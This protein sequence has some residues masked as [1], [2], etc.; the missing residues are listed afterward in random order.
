[1]NAVI[2]FSVVVV[3]LLVL[4]T[5][6]FAQLTGTKTV[7]TGGDYT[8]L[9][10]AINDLNTQGVGSG[11]VT[12]N[13]AA[14]ETFNENPP[15]ITATGTS[16]DPIVF[17]KNGAGANPLVIPST[18]GTITSTTFGANADAIIKIVGGDYI[19][20]NGIDVQD[21]A[22]FTTAT[23]KFEYGYML[24]K[25]SGTDA[26]KNVTIRNATITLDKT[27]VI[28]SGVY[29]SNVDGAGAAVTVTS[30]G[31]RSE[32]VKIHNNTI[33]NI[34]TGIQLRG[35]NHTTAPRDYYDHFVDVGVDGAN[36][37]TNYGGGSATAYGVYAIYQ[38]SLKLANNTINGGTG[39]TTTLYGIFTSTG[40]NSAVDIYGN[41]VTIAGGGTTSTIYA[42]NN[43]MGASGTDNTVNIYNNIVENCSYP[44]ATSGTLYCLYQSTSPMTVNI[45][46]NTVRNNSKPGTGIMYC[47]YSFNTATNGA[48]NVYNNTVHGNSNTGTGSM[49]CVYSNEATTTAK[50]TYG[51]TVYGNS[52]A[53]GTLYGLNSST[54]GTTHVFKNN[55][56]DLSNSG[57]TG[58]VYGI[59]IGSGVTVY[60]YNNFVSDL[61]TP[62]SDGDDRIRGIYEVS[63]TSSN[64]YYF[65]YNTVYLD[66]TSTGTNFST[67]AI[68]ANTGPTVEMR[69]NILINK[70]TPT[71]TGRA[72]VYRRSSTTIG[73]YST[74]SN[75]NN[76]YAGTPSASNLIFYDGTNSD[77]TIGDFKTRVSPADGNSFTE[78]SPFV[79]VGTTPYNLH[80]QTTVATQTE[81][82]GQAI[83]TP[84]ITQDFDGDTRNATT[85]DVGAD[86]FNGIGADLTSPAISYDVLP[87]TYLTGNR[88]IKARITD[89]SG[90]QRSAAGSPR[91]YYKK[92]SGG[93]YFSDTGV[94]APADSFSF[95][96]NTATLGG[97]T[98]GDTV[99]YYVAAQDSLNNAGTNPGGTSPTINPPNATVANPNFY[100]VQPTIS[101]T[102]TIGAGPGPELATFATIKAFF[103]SVNASFVDGDIIANITSD[104]AETATATLNEVAYASGGP[105]RILV[106][107]SGGSWVASGDIAGALIDL[108]GA[109]YVTFDGVGKT[110][111]YRN[112]NTASTARTFL[113]RTDATVDTIRNSIIEGAS[114]STVS[115]VIVVSTSV[116]GSTGNSNLVFSGNDIRDRSDVTGVPANLIYA[117][118]T[119]AAPNSNITIT[120]NNLFNWTNI[121]V[122]QSSTGN[123][124]GWSI[125]SN[126]FY[127]TA[128]R[129]ATLKGIDLNT[130]SGHTVS[131]N[132]FGGSAPNRS[133]APLTNT[134]G[135]VIAFEFTVGTTAPT[136]IQ[137]NTFSNIDNSGVTLSHLVNVTGGNVNIGTTTGN[138]IGGG[139]AAY[140]TIRTNYDIYCIYNTGSGIVNISNNTIRYVTNTSIG[141]DWLNGIRSTSGT[142][143]ITNNTIRN[144]TTTATSTTIGSLL[145]GIYISASTAAHLVEGNTIKD[146]ASLATGTSAYPVS[147]MY[148]SVT[149][150]GTV[151]SRNNISGLTVAGTGTGTGS[152]QVFGIYISS[153]RGTYVNNMI[154]V[155]I[156]AGDESRIV[157]IR[158][159]ASS[160]YSNNFYYNTVH[161]AGAT[162]TGVNNSYAFWRS[163]ADTVSIMNNIFNNTRTTGGT[164]A[165]LAI[166]NT[167]TNANG[168]DVNASNYNVLNAV[169]SSAVGQ[170]LSTGSPTSMSGWQTES[171]GDNNS[172]SGVTVTFVDAANG[173][174]HMNMGTTPTSLESAGTVILSYTT[175]YDNQTRPGPPG[176]VNGGATAPDLGADEFDGVPAPL[177]M[178]VSST[179]AQGATTPV[180][181]GT[182]DNGII[183]IQVVTS[184][185][186]NPLNATSITFNTAGSTNPADIANAKVF[187]TGTSDVFST[188]NQFGST[189]ATPS[190]QMV[191]TGTQAL[192]TGTNYFW[193]SYDIAS[194]A[195]ISNVV[196]GQA[197]AVVVGGVNRIPSVTN[198]AGSRTI[199]GPFSGNYTIGTAQPAPYNSITSALAA[200]MLASAN[201]PVTFLLEDASYTET[202]PVVI[203]S[204]P[205]SSVTNTLTIKPAPATTV[206]I[207]G[208]SG[209]TSTS[210]FKFNRCDYVIIDGSNSGG[211]SRD[212]TIENTSTNTS[213]AAIWLSSGG[214][215]SGATNNVIK[216]CILKCGAD[217]STGTNLTFGIISSGA[218]I[219][220]ATDGDDND[221]NTFQNNEI[222]KVR[223]GIYLRG[224]VANQNDGNTI[225]GNLVGPT[226]FGSDQIGKDGIVVEHQ[227]A[228]TITQ[229]TIRY[230]GGTF[231]TTTSGTDR[232]A[233]GLGDDA[234]TSPLA[235]AISNATVTRNLIY[236]IIEERTF[237]AVGILVASTS[238]P[239]NNLIANNVM[240]N[241]RANGTVSDHAV[242]I[243]MDDLVGDVV[244]FNSIS[245]IGD[246]DPAPAT[247]ATQS[248]TGIRI[249]IAADVTNLTL[250]DNAIHIDLTSN[251]DTLRHYAIV[252]P[253]A[254]YSWGT[255]GAD[256]ND[257]YVNTANAQMAL[258]GL[259]TSVPYTPVTTLVAWQGTFTPPQ[260]AFSIAADPMYNAPNDLR[261]L[262]GSPLLLA[263]VTI[264]GI[265]DDFLGTPRGG[266]PTI[267]GYEVAGDFSG[268]FIGYTLLGNTSSTSNRSLPGVA[269]TDVSGVNVTAGT[270]PRVYYKRA[271]DANAFGGANN[272]TFNGWKW[273]ETPGTTSPFSFT[274]D[275]S[276]L[277]G[278]G[279]VTAGD[280]V[281][282]FVV[283]QDLAGPF[284]S[285]NP[286]EGF[287]ATSVGSI[288]SGPNV[289]NS[290]KIIGVPMAGDFTIGLLDFNK[291]SGK[292]LTIGYTTKIVK[293]EVP[294]EER[295]EGSKEEHLTRAVAAEIL[296]PAP[297]A[298]LLQDRP[299]TDVPEHAALVENEEVEIPVRIRLVDVEVVVPVLM[300]GDVPYAGERSAPLPISGAEGGPDAV[301]PTITAAMTD[302]AERGVGGAVRFL[303]VDATYPSETYPISVGEI[304]GSSSVNTVTLKPQTGI[305]PV[306]SGDAAEMFVLEGA[307]NFIFDGSNTLAGTTRDMTIRNINTG[308]IA[309][310][311]RNDATSNTIKNC[312]LE[313]G[314]TGSTEATIMFSTG[315]AD[316]NSGNTI[317]NNAIRDRSDVTS[318]APDNGIYSSG[319]TTARNS[320]NTITNNEIFNFGE[321]GVE[322]SSTGNG[323]GWVIS[324][325]HFYDNTGTSN[326]TSRVV[327][328]ALGGINSSGNTIEDNFIGG[329]A[330]NAGGTPWLVGGIFTGI[331][332]TCDSV[333]QSAIDN[334]TVQNLSLTGTGSFTGIAVTTGRA[335]ISN[336]TVGHN[337]TANSILV[338]GTSTT[339]G[340]T[341]SSTSITNPSTVTGNLVANLN[342]TGTGTSVRVR[343][344]NF[345][346]ASQF[347][348]M[349]N[350]IHSLATNST[351]TGIGATSPVAVG[352]HM[353]T[354]STFYPGVL[355]GNTVY[356]IAA[357]NTG[358][359]GSVATGMMLTNFQGPATKNLIYDV[360]NL[361]TGT[362]LT[363]PPIA[364]GVYMR[365]MDAAEFSN[366]MISVGSDQ[367]TNTQFN[368]VWNT[369][370][371][372]G[373][374][375][376]VAYNSISVAG[377][378]SSG[379]IPGFA[380]MRGDNTGF[381]PNTALTLRN[382]VF[383]N[384]RSGGTGKH[385]AIANQSTVP[386]DTGW[387]STASNYNVLH[388]SN[389]ATLGLWAS[390]DQTFAG[391]QTASG[392]DSNSVTG[393]PLFVGAIDLHITDENSP[394]SNAGTPIVGITTD[395][396]GETRNA[397][398]PDIGGDE[399]GGGGTVTIGVPVAQNWN[400][401]SLPVSDPVP[402]DSVKH[403]YVNSAN[404]YAFAFVGGYVQRFVMEPGPGYWVK[405][406][407]AYTQ[408]ITGTARDTLSIPVANNWNMIGSISTSIDT[409]VAHVTPTPANLRASNYFRYAAGYVVATTIDPGS[410]YWVK[411]NGAG[412]FFMHVTGPSAKAS[413]EPTAAGKSIEDLN[414]LT[415]QDANGGSQ[416]LYFGADGNNEIPVAMF[417]MPPAPPAGSFDARFESAEGGL[418][419]QTHGDEVNTVVD[420]PITVQSSAPTGS[421][422]T[423]S[424]KVNGTTASYELSDGVVSHAVRGEGTLKITNSEASHLVLKV[425]GSGVLPEEFALMQ[426]YPNPFNPTTNIRFAL[427]VESR[428]TV[429]IYNVLGQRVKTL[430][431]EQRAAGFHTVEWNGTG[432]SGQQLGSGAYFLRLE[433]QG[434]DGSSFNQFRKMVLVK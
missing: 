153:G 263:G 355:S 106:R 379:A 254:A 96:I 69:N 107:P 56:Y 150:L 227:D 280:T 51:N 165:D 6:A 66:A 121:A 57:A 432:V 345:T 388:A 387:S 137:G 110:M 112:A 185:F 64:S 290:Y 63:S 50:M 409:S 252:A 410:G 240:Y 363:L 118:G 269:I 39:T 362:T 70:S 123:G 186:S 339:H 193:L 309:I 167:N 325:N 28:S 116:G 12:F 197:E 308:G 5:G 14:D 426:N 188:G 31:G 234:W 422:L 19:T 427:P 323:G 391:W 143:T 356:D 296:A 220:S 283:A 333:S 80:M 291:A 320:S 203:D 272:N 399:F 221:N 91:M 392:G 367:T 200:L 285:A 305:S 44:T 348:I 24:A 278:G 207:S 365:F 146:L 366:N 382:N 287:S 196:D 393:D 396:D 317:T 303:L 65:Y 244:V 386:N 219:G 385:Y 282:Y 404:P 250:K 49:Y 124:D 154:S 179:S 140:D 119:T 293:Q 183:N 298:K 92:N 29:V 115:G 142:N 346:G 383:S 98:A 187:Y 380:F 127:Q 398:T 304:V 184:G 21:N 313:G 215:G 163:S 105:Y 25:A 284:V 120:G 176:S 42:I 237:S 133:G 226:A 156:G 334:N 266:T 67:A 434:T 286:Y 301:Y 315:I 138:I 361:S 145:N 417:A 155:G 41:T 429:E 424:W 316:G 129:A 13:V 169:V 61:R 329:T 75:S 62:A 35:Y 340:I 289:P 74:A 241:I 48:A 78:N 433:A 264:P 270:K 249:T 132:S 54:G 359:L 59:Y 94:E 401:V 97:V 85:P 130:G 337:T 259:G 88:S 271:T 30:T 373:N 103:D 319:T 251:T 343:G 79:N 236:N 128:N 321:S 419:V 228:V 125:S 414:T 225:S 170:W 201:G 403:I 248:G 23:E 10:A 3:F 262:P 375:I 394:A 257:Y 260:D 194:G 213:T 372:A 195:T 204:F 222:V 157:G 276:L 111:T 174:L 279:G 71:G 168:W 26:P 405:S 32:N 360:R 77:Q 310:L 235:T 68:Y 342:A 357:N 370:G 307:D 46:G 408:N 177:M 239:S 412:S 246:I 358:A 268:P 117:S 275:Y 40:T 135:A 312:V 281:Q 4:S 198:P 55:I 192:V 245:M 415:I 406:T 15:A 258:G 411:A 223:Y 218:T 100:N 331:T 302:L 178:Y 87:G 242:G 36:N 212:L 189:I 267:G 327:I 217:Q 95:T 261:P 230:V 205:G 229:N 206:L 416:T 53:G 161:V 216:N 60:T 428:V 81:S 306:I 144:L 407:T 354:G 171:G 384:T 318:T 52:T 211:S 314:N 147:G 255:G 395:F 181:Q 341:V 84:S 389:P 243:A 292:D 199:Q 299:M 1:M 104:V 2:R 202:F 425:T 377:T 152:P 378:A 27:V 122:N 159:L 294:V 430:I 139:A 335:T 33:S 22:A 175:D 83:S 151:F 300:D 214:P 37:I 99:F 233:I 101:G 141:A 208:N 311:L 18:A 113:F 17:Q 9:T 277:F 381:T 16:A 332:M 8:T 256:Y 231:A 253:S 324:G 160:T 347:S 136:E 190:G 7:G 336:N 431:N 180:Y 364:S 273:A 109:D 209:G 265:T 400:I 368:G 166:A 172:Q 421:G 397:T 191:F 72:V 131:N 371:D 134:T 326:T 148:V 11:G 86:E 90:V 295:A 238:S 43:G 47:L 76:L 162:T 173:N 338:A 413:G 322:L 34:Y 274:L 344:I 210:I 108:N 89:A 418:M 73:T 390:T 82:G 114:T 423:V 352:I 247:T 353:F 297:A 369:A 224:D 328:N 45:Y 158:D 351:G 38:D 164:G 374:D 349:N 102:V 420:F 93:S 182:V 20:F 126:S 376:L 149:P 402:D 350:V 288:L 58:I 330:P 232:V